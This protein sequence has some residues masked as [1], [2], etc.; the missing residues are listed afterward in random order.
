MKRFCQWAGC[1]NPATVEAGGWWHC[2]P[3]LREHHAFVAAEY[4]AAYGR[5]PSPERLRQSG[6]AA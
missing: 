3:H 2:Q 5:R 4:A 1:R 6:G